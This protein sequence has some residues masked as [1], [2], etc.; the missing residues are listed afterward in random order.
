MN[1]VIELGA[2]SS[3]V[4][5]VVTRLNHYKDKIKNITAIVT[6]DDDT[7][8]IYSDTHKTSVATYHMAVMQRDVFFNWFEES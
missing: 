1:E 4:G 2:Q 3:T 5:S 7:T 6:W 8:A